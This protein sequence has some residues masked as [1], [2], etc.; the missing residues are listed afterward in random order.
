MRY[1]ILLLLLVS[2]GCSVDSIDIWECEVDTVSFNGSTASIT[3]KVSLNG[4]TKY[5]TETSKVS[6]VGSDYVIGDDLI[7]LDGWREVNGTSAEFVFVYGE[8]L[9]PYCMG[10]FPDIPMHFHDDFDASATRIV[11]GK[12]NAGKWK[13]KKRV[14]K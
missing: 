12:A 4:V 10:L 14:N 8:E 3:F 7:R 6:L 2:T 9:G 13:V 11:S 5:H 1:I